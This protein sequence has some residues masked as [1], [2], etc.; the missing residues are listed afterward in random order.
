LVDNDEVIRANRDVALAQ[1][2]LTMYQQQQA[3]FAHQLAVLVGRTPVSAEHLQRGNL[4]QLS[5][6][7]QT[8]VGLPAELV[9][10]RPD[11]LASEKRLER[12]AIDVRV[13]RKAFLPTINLGGQLTLAS[14][15]F[16]DVFNWDNKVDVQNVGIKQPLFQGGKLIAGVRFRQAR[17]REQLENYR[18][19]ILTAFREVEDQ[20]ALLKSNYESLNS[21]TERLELTKDS[22]H[23]A[24]EQYQQGLIPHL[25]VLQSETNLAQY[26]QLIAQ[27]KADAMIATVNLF[28]ALGGGF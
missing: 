14:Q 3:L 5:L 11:I 1:T 17:Q 28:K 26:Q 27:S 13:A 20:L 18:Q 6:P 22:L 10:R 19:T 15:R 24:E 12:A 8:D 2:S 25:N 4:D 23:I 16:Q 9:E 7:S 21:N